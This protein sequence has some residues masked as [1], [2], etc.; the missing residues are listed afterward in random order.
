VTQVVELDESHHRALGEIDV[1]IFRAL[2]LEGNQWNK[3][4]PFWSIRLRKGV[5]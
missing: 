2:T 3:S 4:V 1:S 5:S